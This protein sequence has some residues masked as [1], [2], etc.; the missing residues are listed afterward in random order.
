M[1]VRSHGRPV[2]GF[3]PFESGNEVGEDIAATLAAVALRLAVP[4]LARGMRGRDYGDGEVDLGLEPSMC[5]SRHEHDSGGCEPL[6][7]HGERSVG[8]LDILVGDVP[9]ERAAFIGCRPQEE[10]DERDVVGD[11]AGFRVLR[12]GVA[13]DLKGVLPDPM[14]LVSEVLVVGVA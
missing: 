5:Q 1:R 13:N 12:A 8:E 2:A 4:P 10:V 9:P 7:V 11:L 14:C 6:Q 3:G